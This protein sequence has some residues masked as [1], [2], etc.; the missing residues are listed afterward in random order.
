MR[1]ADDRPNAA[2]GQRTPRVDPD[3]EAVRDAAR[4]AGAFGVLYRRYVDRVYSYAFYQLGDHHDAEDATER[5][6]LAALRALGSFREEAGTF[7]A[8]LFRIARNTVLNVHRSRARRSAEPIEVA[9]P[10]P[11][12]PDEDPAGIAVRAEEARR[13]R[14][15]LRLLPEERRQAVILRFADGLSAREIGQVLDRSEGAVRVLIHR[16][17]K[18]L[19]GHLER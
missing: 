1:A 2:D 18:E 8:W 15:A 5:T 12:A 7:R 11:P 6:F 17:L 14:D 3:A 19:G 4:D 16:A 9:F 10:E 13:V